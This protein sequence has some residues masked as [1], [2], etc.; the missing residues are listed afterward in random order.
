ME[1]TRRVGTN[2]PAGQREGFGPVNVFSH[3][4]AF[5]DANFKAVVRP[6]FDTLHSSTW[7]DLRDG[8]MV[9]TAPV[10]ADGR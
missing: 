9:V 5:P 10:D 8:P 6:N 4:R 2:V 3:F 7:L 1:L